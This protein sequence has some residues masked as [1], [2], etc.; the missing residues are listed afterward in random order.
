MNRLFQCVTVLLIVSFSNVS[1]SKDSDFVTKVMEVARANITSAKLLDG[2]FVPPETLEEKKYPIIPFEDAKRVVE[3]GQTSGIAAWCGV[4]WEKPSFIKLME[5]ERQKS[6]W[7]D[8]QLAYIGLVHG[9]SMGMVES[10][11]KAKECSEEQAQHIREI[12]N[13]R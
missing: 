7:S 12:I 9:V 11:M 3:V 13:K 10:V 1:H 8:K 5:K 4:E 2:S 6:T